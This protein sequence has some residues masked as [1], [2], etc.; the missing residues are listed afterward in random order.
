MMIKPDF[1]RRCGLL[2]MGLVTIFNAAGIAAPQ[3][4]FSREGSIEQRM[5]Q[6]LDESSGT[7]D[8]AVFEFSSHPLATGLKRALA[9]GVKVRLLLDGSKVQGTSFTPAPIDLSSFEVRRLTGRSPSSGLM[10]DKFAI[11]DH[12]RVATGSYN[13]TAGAEH[14]NYE[15]VLLEDDPTVVDAYTRQFERLWNEASVDTR[16]PNARRAKPSPRRPRSPFRNS[17]VTIAADPPVKKSKKKKARKRKKSTLSSQIQSEPHQ[18][19]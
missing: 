1:I 12:R 11:F 2:L 13:W 6:W 14:S 18:T 4:Y 9:R 8:L 7:I 10:H 16:K 17:R 3:A 15:N 5:L 19:A